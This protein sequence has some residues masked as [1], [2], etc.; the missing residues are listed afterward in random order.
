MP[1]ISAPGLR[2]LH[3]LATARQGNI[4]LT[5]GSEG[6][7]HSER[8][9]LR[10]SWDEQS[11]RLDWRAGRHPTQ[12]V[13]MSVDEIRSTV[14]E[15][16]AALLRPEVPQGGRS[17]TRYFGRARWEALSEQGRESGEAQWET[18]GPPHPAR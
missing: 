13:T 16:T 10:L 6:C 1:V 18:R 12:L 14:E 15:M 5:L 3:A 17:T 8:T 9:E 2:S 4:E 11:G 7:F